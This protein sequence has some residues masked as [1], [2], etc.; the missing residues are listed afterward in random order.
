MSVALITGSAGLIGS[1]TCRHFHARGFDF[2][3]IDNDLRAWS[4]GPE[5]STLQTRE[6]LTSSLARYRHHAIDIRYPPSEKPEHTLVLIKPDNF[7]F[8]TGRPGNV[9]VFFHGP[10]FTLWPSKCTG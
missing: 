6:R 3:G 2:V 5:A 9:I 7:R 8:P 10:A 4:F 1:E